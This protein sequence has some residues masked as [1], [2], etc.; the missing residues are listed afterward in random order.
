VKR[1]GE[2]YNAELEPNDPRR[3][4]GLLHPHTL[5]H[6]FG[7]F[8]SETTDANAYELQRALGHRSQRYIELYTRP[9][10]H[11]RASYVKDF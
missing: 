11:V 6:T 1:I 7:F 10:G 4:E 2:L 9:P 8:L 5:R 3:I